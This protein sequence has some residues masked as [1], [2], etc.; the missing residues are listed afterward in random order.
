MEILSTYLIGDCKMDTKNAILYTQETTNVQSI[1]TLPEV[2]TV[3]YEY[4][5]LC[6]WLGQSYLFT[7]LH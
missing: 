7:K 2:N 6:H 4:I 1:K 3:K 5:W